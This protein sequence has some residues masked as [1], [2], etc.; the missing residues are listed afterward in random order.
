MDLVKKYGKKDKNSI[1]NTLE[2]LYDG[3]V[4]LRPLVILAV[5]FLLMGPGCGELYYGGWFF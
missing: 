2:C 1:T 5:L 3:L 4:D